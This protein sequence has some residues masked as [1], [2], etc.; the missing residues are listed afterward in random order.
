MCARRSGSMLSAGTKSK[1]TTM[2]VTT[3]LFILFAVGMVAMHLFGHG[4]H[5]GHG[6]NGGHG[7]HGGHGG[8]GGC[9][10]GGRQHARPTTPAPSDSETRSSSDSATPRRDDHARHAHH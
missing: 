7:S 2:D 4:S 8:H 9:G 1:G 5:G 3:I 10:H 6:S